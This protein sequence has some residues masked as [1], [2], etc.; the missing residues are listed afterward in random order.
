MNL[1]EH[2]SHTPLQSLNKA[3]HSGFE[4]QRRHHQK[5]K[6]GVSVAQKMDTSP[7]KNFLKKSVLLVASCTILCELRSESDILGPTRY[8]DRDAKRKTSTESF[9]RL[10]ARG[11]LGRMD[12]YA[13][14]RFNKGNPEFT[15]L[16]D[17]SSFILQN[18]RYL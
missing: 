7:T 2:I 9:Y 12:I 18:C 1:R 6:T 11:Q 14:L 16:D 15:D 10:T 17:V 5:S 8:R 13:V 4:T 3:A